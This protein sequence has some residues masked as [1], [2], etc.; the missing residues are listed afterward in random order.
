MKEM[1]KKNINFRLYR[2]HLLTLSTDESQVSMFPKKRMKTSEII[3]K[4]NV[5]FDTVLSSLTDSKNNTNP[6]RLHDHDDEYYVFKIA[7]KKTT[8]ITQ[9]FKNQFISN[10]PYSYVIINNNN[11]IQK[12]A[13]SENGEAFSNTQ[14]VKNILSK[15]FKKELEKFQLNIAIEPLFDSKNFWEYVEK[16]KNDLTYINFQYIKPNLASIS[17]SLPE[18]FKKFAEKVNSHESHLSIKAPDNGILENIN[19]QNPIIN[20][21]VEYSSQGAGNIK[22]KV[23]K[24]RKQLNTSDKPVIQQIDELEIEGAPEQVFKLYKSIV[25]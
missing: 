12:I 20:G 6:I 19:K 11:N 13:I 17:K 25:E 4:K 15:V 18:D 14:V 22:L 2:Y 9:D 16:Y 10:E 24:I 1:E 21:L 8:R 5:F 23:K 3:Q 7:Q